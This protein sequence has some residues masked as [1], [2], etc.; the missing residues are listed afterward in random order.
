[1]HQNAFCTSNEKS[2]FDGS[3]KLHFNQNFRD[4]TPFMWPMRPYIQN[5]H[6]F[7]KLTKRIL[8]IYPQLHKPSQPHFQHVYAH[9]SMPK[10][11]G[12]HASLH[13]DR[14][15]CVCD[16]KSIFLPSN[17]ILGIIFKTNHIMALPQHIPSYLHHH[18]SHLSIKLKKRVFLVN[19]SKEEMDGIVGIYTSNQSQGQ[20]QFLNWCFNS[21]QIANLAK[22]GFLT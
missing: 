11:W 8:L 17:L 3:P 7:Q 16:L 5:M 13:P 15:K 10:F 6:S 19:G 2:R 20:L 9:L 1:M 12:S 22:L 21:V 4:T 18:I 14:Q